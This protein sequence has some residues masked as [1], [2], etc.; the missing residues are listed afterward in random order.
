MEISP[1]SPRGQSRS[2]KWEILKRIRPLSVVSLG[3]AVLVGS[4]LM[5]FLW[6]LGEVVGLIGSLGL[7]LIRNDQC[8]SAG[9]FFQK[10]QVWLT[11]LPIRILIAARGS[12]KTP[13]RSNWLAVTPG[14]VSRI[15]EGLH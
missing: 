3:R 2:L 8:T 9:T 11:T 4:G 14:I 12:G 6:P 13:M 15:P 1:P 10:P 7:T 5:S